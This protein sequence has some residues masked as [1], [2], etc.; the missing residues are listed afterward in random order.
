MKAIG[1]AVLALLLMASFGGEANAQR[2]SRDDDDSRSARE[3]RYDR[4]RDYDRDRSSSRKRRYLRERREDRVSRDDADYGRRYRARDRSRADR[5]CCERSVHL[6]QRGGRS[7]YAQGPRVE[8]RYVAYI[9]VS[10]YPQYPRPP[11]ATV[12]QAD[13][14]PIGTRTWWG[15]I[16]R[17]G[18]TGGN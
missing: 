5:D 8:Y 14:H 1:A 13:F 3:S 18:R 15:Q 4:D 2:Y 7:R 12:Y 11:R 9:P 17:E 6:Y 16:E 10:R